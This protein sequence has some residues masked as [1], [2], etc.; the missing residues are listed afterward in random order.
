MSKTISGCNEAKRVRTW[1]RSEPRTVRPTTLT[2]LPFFSGRVRSSYE[3]SFSV[4]CSSL[5]SPQSG[6]PYMEL[7]FLNTDFRNSPVSSATRH[8]PTN[9]QNQQDNRSIRAAKTENKTHLP[10]NQWSRSHRNGVDTHTHTHTRAGV[11]AHKPIMH[12]L[13]GEWAFLTA[14]SLR[15]FC[16]HGACFQSDGS[17]FIQ[18]AARQDRTLSPH[19]GSDTAAG[20]L[21]G[22]CD[23]ESHPRPCNHPDVYRFDP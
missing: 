15:A 4:P 8:V 20:P 17:L 23:H 1:R 16:L 3:M 12:Q 10:L 9:T 18:P 5:S 2:A 13:L 19:N 11:A 22:R 7:Y 21:S 14:T 6:H